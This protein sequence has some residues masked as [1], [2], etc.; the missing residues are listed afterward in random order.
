LR[1]IEGIFTAYPF[2]KRDISED[3]S[4]S[5]ITI[6]SETGI[7]MEEF[8]RSS[9]STKEKDMNEKDRKEIERKKREISTQGLVALY[10]RLLDRMK[11]KHKGSAHK[12]L[13]ALRERRYR[14]KRAK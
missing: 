5:D 6:G 10:Q 3:S 4:D 8:Y 13:D 14:E 1:V 2:K 9:V 11:I 7:E 12:R